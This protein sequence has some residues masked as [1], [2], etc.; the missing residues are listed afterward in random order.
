MVQIAQREDSLAFETLN[1]SI[2]DAETPF[3]EISAQVKA[4][5]REIN[6]DAMML[7]W[8][9]RKNGEGFPNYECSN[10]KPFWEMF[11]ESRGFNLKIVVNDGDYVFYY[12]KL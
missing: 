9:N 2:D 12:L 8:F 11:A 7:S 5:A 3:A 10:E 4:Q 6:K 1:L